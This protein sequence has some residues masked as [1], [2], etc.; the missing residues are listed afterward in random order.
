MVFFVCTNQIMFLNLIKLKEAVEYFDV[1]LLSSFL[2][3]LT[4]TSQIDDAI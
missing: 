4:C 2:L 1:F 3:S